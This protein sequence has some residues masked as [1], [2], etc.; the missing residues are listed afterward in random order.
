MLDISPKYI[1]MGLS[2]VQ[3]SQ[4][5]SGAQADEMASFLPLLHSE[6]R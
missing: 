4:A 1:E 5:I 3:R 6:V 2:N